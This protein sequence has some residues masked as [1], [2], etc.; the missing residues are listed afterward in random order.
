MAIGLGRMFGFHFLE[1]FDH[2]YISTSITE[3]WRR[4]HI[5][6]S[7]WFREYV[8]IPLGG[9]RKGVAANV[10]NLLIVWALTGLW[11]GASVNFILW[12]LYYGVL[13]ILE[14]FVFAP[15]VKKCNAHGFGHLYTMFFVIAGWVI[16]AQTDMSA[17][18]T[19]LKAMVGIGVPA[20]SSDFLYYLST[21]AVLL[22]LLVICS[23]D[24]KRAKEMLVLWRGK[25]PVRSA[26]LSAV[27]MV[28]LLGLSTAFLVGD[29]YNPFL[30]FR[31]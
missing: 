15:V 28:L 20:V 3:F 31:F 14:K 8:Y 5:S 16:F 18:G 22:V 24:W 10:R 17:L 1:N 27:W 26:V 9:N 19:Y 23:L 6:L 4:W 11:H 21:N 12:G 13:L 29:S 25:F 7:G 30:Y 2:P